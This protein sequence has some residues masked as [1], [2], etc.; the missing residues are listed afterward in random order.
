LKKIVD[1]VLAQCTSDKLF[2]DDDKFTHEHLQGTA[3]I[4]Y[5]RSVID[6]I[7]YRFLLHTPQQKELDR[8]YYDI[9]LKTQNRSR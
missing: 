4:V 8:P 9:V 3:N 1:H 2:Y 5:K 7:Y 6:K